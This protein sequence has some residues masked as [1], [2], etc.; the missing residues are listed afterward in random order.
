MT[1][2]TRTLIVLG[3]LALLA[4]SL[5]WF[6]GYQWAGRECIEGGRGADLLNGREGSIQ[7][8]GDSCRATTPSGQVREVPLSDWQW[9]GP[10]LGAAT[11][12]ALALGAAAASGWRRRPAVQA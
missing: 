1:T 4:G 6:G 5:I 10:A 2:L 3:V 12:G 11:A 8:V 9:D 7:I